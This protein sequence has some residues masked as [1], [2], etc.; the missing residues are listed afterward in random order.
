M[1]VS[2]MSMNLQRPILGNGSV[3][4]L[5][6]VEVIKASDLRSFEVC[7]ALFVVDAICKAIAFLYGKYGAVLF[8]LFMA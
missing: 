8:L 5:E 6:T 4:G 2:Q 3:F 7:F 1:I